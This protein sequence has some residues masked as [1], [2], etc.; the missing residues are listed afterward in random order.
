[1]CTCTP[2]SHQTNLPSS[3]FGQN[4]LSIIARKWAID[5]YSDKRELFCQT[6]LASTQE[7][8]VDIHKVENNQ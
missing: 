6:L 7:A 5:E 8:E 4:N 2:A 3:T 1:M